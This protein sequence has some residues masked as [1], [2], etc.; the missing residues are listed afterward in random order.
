MQDGSASSPGPSSQ[1]VKVYRLNAE[2]LWDDKGTGHISVEYLEQSDSVGLV[3]VSEDDARPLL[4]HRIN[5]KEDIYQRQ[6]GA[7]ETIITWTDPEVGT[8]IALSFAEVVGC[9]YI[10]DQI[11]RVQDSTT[12]QAGS[13]GHPRVVDEYDTGIDD[14]PEVGPARPLE[15]PLADLNSLPEL[16]KA[17]HEVSFLQ[18]ET[19][20]AQLVQNNYVRKV[21]DLFR[22]CED[23]EDRASL[24]QVYGVVRGMVL[25]GETQLLEALL[26][27]DNILDVVGALE[28]EPGLAASPRYREFLK[29][30][31][32][33]KEVVPIQ[34]PAVRQRIHASYHIG[35]LKD[36]VLPRVL[37]DQAFAALSSLMLFY[38]HDVLMALQSDTYFFPELF[39][40]LNA[41]PVG[42]AEWVDLVRFLQELCGQAKHLQP[43]NRQ[44]LLSRL[45]TLGLFDVI[46]KVIG[47]GDDAL[48]YKAVDVLLSSVGHDPSG[49]RTYMLETS[50]KSLFGQLVALLVVSDDAGLQEQILEVLRTLLD[51][52]SM[53]QT[54]EKD[55]FLELFYERHMG[56]LVGALQGHLPDPPA[57]AASAPAAAG[58]WGPEG[59]AGVDPQPAGTG[60]PAA[61]A[62]A[63]GQATPA[64]GASRGP[65]SQ[66]QQPSQ[67]TGPPR[68]QQQQ[69]QRKASQV[70]VSARTLGL[71]VELLCFC[72]QHHGYRIKYYT[73]RNNVVE[74]VLKLLKRR[75]RWLVVA[76]VRFLRTC[77][78]LKDDFYN[79]YITRNSLFEPVFN[80]F[81][82]NGDRYNLLNSAVLELVD[83]VRRENL[84]N[85]VSHVVDNYYSQLAG[86]EYV[87][88]FRQLKHKYDQNAEREKSSG[89]MVPSGGPASSGGPA[90]N[91]TVGG[92]TSSGGSRDSGGAG[93]SGGPTLPGMGRRGLDRDEEDYF[94]EEE[95]E[96]EGDAAQG[97]RRGSATEA[98][99]GGGGVP[100]LPGNGAIGALGGLPRLVDYDDDDD[101]DADLPFAGSKHSSSDQP[102]S[103]SIA[104]RPRTE[105]GSSEGSPPQQQSGGKITMSIKSS[106]SIWRRAAR[107]G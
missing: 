70:D 29:Q 63:E 53:D 3:V 73:L 86:I 2:G 77:I 83:F 92:R 56:T 14:F 104:K 80:V 93:P 22:Q 49:L 42:S 25:L 40:R 87:D 48:Q 100:S 50:G 19:L 7:E 71:V 44:Q 16:A 47:S 21:L 10:W 96:E 72:V 33:Y 68:G 32:V 15:L 57:P 5:T 43:S 13:P 61:Q 8:D 41:T 66:P 106:G 76:A 67:D 90:G 46:A 94:N 64:A 82:A 99:P 11:Q 37:D 102:G 39:S 55:S 6:T 101:D 103:P 89:G 78:G 105:P 69:N 91:G 4:I 51:P 88:T 35:Y 31:V 62:T 95:E 54:P 79:R 74:K 75:E 60:G 26:E 12:R 17:L 107:T 97:G 9:S 84:K 24:Q 30:Q 1:R 52:D 23:L 18:R 65:D 20:A 85:L 98:G 45:T 36:V 38:N 81:F 58:D 28:Y 27:G 34:D 59:G